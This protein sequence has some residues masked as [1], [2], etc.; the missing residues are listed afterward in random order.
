M[1]NEIHHHVVKIIA[2]KMRKLQAHLHHNYRSTIAIQVR[3]YVRQKFGKPA[4]YSSYVFWA[5]NNITELIEY[6]QLMM[7][8]MT[9]MKLNILIFYL[10]LDND[11]IW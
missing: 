4:I 10:L 2:F 1:T 9:I 11:S 7:T 6:D 3:S 5:H 8:K